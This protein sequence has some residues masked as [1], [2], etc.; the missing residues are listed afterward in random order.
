MA[1]S[2]LQLPLARTTCSGFVLFFWLFF[3]NHLLI[4]LQLIFRLNSL[5][6]LNALVPPSFSFGFYSAHSFLFSS[7]T[8]VRQLVIDSAIENRMLIDL[9]WMCL[10]EAKEWVQWIKKST[11]PVT[12]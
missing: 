2:S 3:I 11:S 7:F 9:C 6:D 8:F 10:L 4:S 1:T 5:L 12:I